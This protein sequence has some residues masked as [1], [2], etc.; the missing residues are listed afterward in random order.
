MLN[1]EMSIK[2][3]SMLEVKRLVSTRLGWDVMCSACLC[4]REKKNLH[5]SNEKFSLFVL[6][7]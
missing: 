5:F 3:Y 7:N 1:D 6:R 4:K 2:R